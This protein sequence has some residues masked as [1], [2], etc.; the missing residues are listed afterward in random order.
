M[1]GEQGAWQSLENALWE[2]GLDP[3]QKK[4]QKEQLGETE[5]SVDL[6]TALYRNVR[7]L[8]LVIVQGSLYYDDVG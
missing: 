8:V 1:R 4:N 3:G 7:F 2:P 6:L 5:K